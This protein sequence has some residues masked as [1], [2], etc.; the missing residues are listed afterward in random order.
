MWIR[1]KLDEDITKIIYDT[2]KQI[3]H[4]YNAVSEYD[5]NFYSEIF[6]YICI[7]ELSSKISSK[8]IQLFFKEFDQIKDIVIRV[9]D[10]THPSIDEDTLLI[11]ELG[12]HEIKLPARLFW[13]LL[14]KKA[15]EAYVNKY[16]DRYQRLEELLW[17]IEKEIYLE[18]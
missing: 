10:I 1:E 6:W 4:T 12:K 18:E 17:G 8:H 16:D 11:L 14:P 9:K 7:K 2:S 13:A 5:L 3:T 15:K